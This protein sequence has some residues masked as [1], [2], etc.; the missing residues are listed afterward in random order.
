MFVKSSILWHVLTKPM[1][2]DKEKLIVPK[3]NEEEMKHFDK[4]KGQ[5]LSVQDYISYCAI[6]DKSYSK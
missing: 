2:L 5:G 1:P 6:F 3:L 4:L